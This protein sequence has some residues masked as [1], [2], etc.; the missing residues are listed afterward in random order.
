[1]FDTDTLSLYIVTPLTDSEI[2]ELE[3]A[4]ERE[5]PTDVRNWLAIVGAPQNLCRRL[6]EE[7]QQFVQMQQW[8][9]DHLFA[10]ASDEDLDAIFALDQQGNVYRKDYG[11]PAPEMISGTLAEYVLSN[12]DAP[13]PIAE[14]KWHTQLS[15]TTEQEGKVIGELS[16]A[17]SLTELS[18]W[19]YHDTSPAEVVTHVNRCKSPHGPT[20]SPGKHITAGQV[21]S[22][23]SIVKSQLRT[24]AVTNRPFDTLARSTL[25]LN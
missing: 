10:F 11:Q 22:S 1:M 17:F 7:E 14:T 16:R 24:F 15:F 6:P 13:L 4:C 2:A 19:E 20:K 23:T 5:I 12:L 18:G 21:P 9:P 3:A 25:G 8:V